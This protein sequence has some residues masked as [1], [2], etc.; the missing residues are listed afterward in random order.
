MSSLIRDQCCDS[1]IHIHPAKIKASTGNIY[2]QLRLIPSI[3]QPMI[4]LF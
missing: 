3:A 1:T 4:Q 2:Q